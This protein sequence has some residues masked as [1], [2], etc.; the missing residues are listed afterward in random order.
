MVKQVKT[1]TRSEAIFS[2][3]DKHRLYLKKVWNSK[4][5]IAT[6]VTKYPRHDGQIFQDTTT[7]LIRNN[8]YNSGYGGVYIVNLFTNVHMAEGEDVEEVI[9][10]ES[11]EYI[12]KAV[13]A[14]EE[15]ILAW[16]TTNSEIAT[17]RIKTVNSLV[18]QP[19]VKVKMLLNP[20]TKRIAHPLN[21][22]C[23]GFWMLQEITDTAT[24]KD[25][26]KQNGDDK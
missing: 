7:M 3:D 4:L 13:K 5:P 12:V 8:I 2:D 24:S 14:S 23:R 16:G 15:V 11:D 22:R 20:K 18:Q 25:K 21:P 6:V 1:I 10:E 9:H 19:N 17:D 26:E